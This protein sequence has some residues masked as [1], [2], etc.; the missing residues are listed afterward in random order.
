MTNP[1]LAAIKTQQTLLAFGVRASA[2][3]DPNNF[4]ELSEM[5]KDE[6]AMFFAED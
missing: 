1:V 3:F 6:I 2:T 4:G 5:D